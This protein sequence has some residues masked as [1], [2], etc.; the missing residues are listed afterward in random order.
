ML[1]RR[2]RTDAELSQEELAERAR[3]SVD[4]ISALE[5]G[6]RRAPQRE[7]VDL[8][9]EALSPAGD[10][11]TALVAAANR[12][13]LRGTKGVA[14]AADAPA[15]NNV[16]AR[17]ATFIGREREVEDLRTRLFAHRLVTVTGTGGVGK[18]ST[19]LQVAAR[20]LSDFEDGVWF[21]ELAPLTNGDYLPSTVAQV[22]GL[23]LGASGDAV[24]NLVLELKDT[25]ALLIFDNCEHIV[26]EAARVISAILHG[27]PNVTLLATSRGALG[28]A[29]EQTYSLPALGFPALTDRPPSAADV[30]QFDAVALF[31]FRAQAADRRFLLTDANAVVIA[32]IC[33]RLD[34]LPLAI[35]LAAARVTVMSPRQVSE[36]LDER[37]RVLTRG[38]RDVLAR[39]QTLRA[40]ID[41]SH[42]LL[43]ERERLLFRRLSVFANGWMLEGA[44]AV[45]QGA[46]L[47]GYDVV[48]VLSSLVDKSLV[49]CEPASEASRYRLLESTR[50]YARER[51]EAA[52]E[53][54]A[55]A[56]RHLCY[57]RDRFIAEGEHFEST[58][59]T[60][61]IDNALECELADVRAALDWALSS[62]QTLLGAELLAAVGNRWGALE[63]SREGLARTEAFLA[64]IGDAPAR[65]L[66]RLWTTVSQWSNDFGRG[67]RA[68]QSAERAVMLARQSDDERTLGVALCQLAHAATK[69]QKF[70]LA[71]SVLREAEALTD[72]STWCA[73]RLLHA[74][75]VLS[76]FQGDLETAMSLYDRLLK[77]Y[78]RLGNARW[79]RH[80][81]VDLAEAE[82]RSGLTGRAMRR[83]GDG[84]ESL[85]ADRNR[86]V[87]AVALTNLAGYCVALD[88]VEQASEAA[89]EAIREYASR[90]PQ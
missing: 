50:L 14:E 53:G 67:A 70:D 58:G 20:V 13:R 21:I 34:G 82:H 28:V 55:S 26:D 7:T 25:H 52:A 69:A 30:A 63:L 18:T 46:D 24:D 76:Q 88:E 31:V 16:P 35:E 33:R 77:E 29:D 86:A 43:D 8:L 37:F 56:E 60:V 10:E 1:L 48:E 79:E 61:E 87:F 17:L 4:A 66:A 19:S 32:D 39:H 5:R 83:L 57:L 84:M 81:T 74:R 9:L 40:L 68:L 90:E 73:L 75:A 22:L 15:P 11:R 3:M 2:L 64:V 89:R 49:L 38:R 45:G 54:A 72:V 71:E 27:C 44:I 47:P 65:L 36:H 6:R 23:T 78:R 59:R 85:R 80:F 62:G 51:L 12:A 41:W 42:D